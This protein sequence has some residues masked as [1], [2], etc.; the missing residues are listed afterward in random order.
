[1]KRILTGDRPT[2][3]LHLGHYIGTLKNRVKL[4]KEYD[5]LIL[6][7]DVQCLTTNFEKPDQIKEDVFNVIA[8]YI[9]SGLDPTIS[10]FVIQ[11]RVPEITEL[12]IYYSMYVLLSTL[13]HNPTIKTEIKAGYNK[14]LTYGFLGYPVNQ[15]A[16]ISVFRADLVPVGRDQV[17]H[18][19]LTRKIV[20]RFNTL[21]DEV[22]VEP[23]AL[24]GD[25]PVLPGLDGKDKMSKSL[26]NAIYLCDEDD[27]ITKKVKSAVTDP[28]RIHP[29]DPGHP[30]VCTIFK[31]YEAFFGEVVDEIREGCKAAQFGCVACK[32]RFA[33]LLINFIKPMR[34]R[35][36]SVR[37]DTDYLTKIALDG[38]A[39]AREIA[40]E[41]MKDVRK[42][43][44]LNYFE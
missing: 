20:R 16:D 27:I 29:T 26:G 40:Q 1:M 32:K 28:A 2:G 19:E 37:S 13:R 33:E 12:T 25:V 17:P 23:D 4:Q 24:V 41:T 35:Y 42:A 31:Y 43:M 44:K 3:N 5:T 21:Y 38:T 7:A 18:I 15:A 34:D 8:S 11:S 30:D 36:K 6:V 9:A 39:Q 14:E 22:L 10:K